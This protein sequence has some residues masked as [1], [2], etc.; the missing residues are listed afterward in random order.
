ML[1]WSLHVQPASGVAQTPGL[2]ARRAL[3]GHCLLAAVGCSSIAP[4]SRSEVVLTHWL[5]SV[6][7][8]AVVFTLRGGADSWERDCQGLYLLDVRNSSDW[9]PMA[10]SACSAVAD[11]R[12]VDVNPV[13]ARW[14]WFNEDADG[15]LSEYSPQS[16]KTRRL[17]S[18]PCAPLPVRPRWSSSGDRLLFP[19]SCFEGDSVR[20]LYLSSDSGA[21]A[22][23]LWEGGESCFA[24][25]AEWSPDDLL[26]A[27]ECRQ[28][29]GARTSTLL[30]LSLS[31]YRHVTLGRGERPEWSSRTNRLAYIVPASAGAA[32][33]VVDSLSAEALEP[34]DASNSPLRARIVWR[35]ASEYPRH[36][37]WSPTGSELVFII[38]SGLVLLT[39]SDTATTTRLVRARIPMHR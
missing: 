7:I 17:G 36:L 38:D 11:V 29:Q 1:T 18:D 9:R 4:P 6:H 39:I 31:S 26:I 24:Q 13:D 34:S 16:A 28:E 5:D 21:A 15:S 14:A 8:E 27:I 12:R 33:Y 3:V 35:S 10:S 25:D 2:H 19:A 37:R 23:L 32:I 30:V 20:G 22:R